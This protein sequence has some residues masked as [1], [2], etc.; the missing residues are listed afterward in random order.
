M[1]S[2]VAGWKMRTLSQAGRTTL[3]KAVATAMPFYCMST[4]L[5][6]KGWCGKID[7][8]LKDFW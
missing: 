2:K 5:L 4:F 6:S 8:M 3:I 7:R 1:L